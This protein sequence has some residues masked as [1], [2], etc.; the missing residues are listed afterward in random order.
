[1][2]ILISNRILAVFVYRILVKR[3]AAA[4]AAV[5][6]ERQRRLVAFR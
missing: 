5:T 2:K 3:L 1:M 4:M 6:G